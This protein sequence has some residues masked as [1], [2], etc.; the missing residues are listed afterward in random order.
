MPKKRGT[1]WVKK[2]AIYSD[3]SDDGFVA[4]WKPKVEEIARKM[5]YDYNLPDSCFDDF[6]S[7]GMNALARVPV[8]SRWNAKYVWMAIRNKLITQLKSA[9]TR[10]SR[11]GYWGEL[12]LDG[13]HLD[14]AQRIAIPVAPDG[15]NTR[16]FLESCVIRLE[17]PNK[18]VVTLYLNG[19][20]EKESA[21]LLGITPQEIKTRMEAAILTMRDHATRVLLQ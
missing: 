15:I 21:A 17:E 1:S 14:P 18:Q 12:P 16:I 6:M 2:S 19:Y 13:E 9:R 7:D 10:L 11:L 20:T 3:I 4:H 8:E 5:I